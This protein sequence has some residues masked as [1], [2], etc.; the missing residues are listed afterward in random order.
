VLRSP[1]QAHHCEGVRA[2]LERAQLETTRFRPTGDLV[3]GRTNY[4]CLRRPSSGWLA[5]ARM[6][7]PSEDISTL[8]VVAAGTARLLVVT[9]TSRVV[10]AS[11]MAVAVSG[12]KNTEG[13]E[14]NP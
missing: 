4:G 6:T 10:V 7:I 12:R 8:V 1:N 13:S 9:R 11:I 14:E 5:K 3:L 2:G